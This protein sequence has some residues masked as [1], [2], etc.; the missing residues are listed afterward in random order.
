[1]AQVHLDQGVPAWTVQ[2]DTQGL[3]PLG[4]QNTSIT[5]YQ[6]LL[7]GISNVTL[8]MRYWSFHTWLTAEYARAHHSA[9]V[10]EWCRFLR[11]G[12]ALYA[13]IAQHNTQDI[14]V[15]GNLW[16][17]RK[18]QELRGDRLAF[19]TFTDRKATTQY[20]QQKFGAFGAA[21][22]S[23]LLEVG[24]IE[25]AQNHDVPVP[26]AEGW[27]LARSFADEIRSF[28]ELFLEV[29][30]RGSVTLAELARMAAMT[31]SSIDE[32]TPECQQY[33]KILFAAG[34]M[35]G[36]PATRRRDTLRLVLHTAH[37]LQGLPDADAVRWV[38]YA[39]HDDKGDAL[40]PL[41]GADG[42]HR[43]RW[44]VYH[45]NDLTHICH[46]SLL[47]YILEVLEGYPGG[48]PLRPLLAEVIERLLAVPATRPRS[49]AELEASVDL[50]A[51]AWSEETDA[52]W[53]LANALL[54]VRVEAALPAQTAFEALRLLAVLGRRLRP[55]RERMWQVLRPAAHKTSQTVFT[56]M[57]F[58]HARRDTPIEELLST[59]LKQRILDRHLAVAFQKLRAGDYTFLFELDEG[60]L[61]LRRKAIAVLTNPRLK[62]AIRFLGDIH[63]LDDSGLTPAGQ[64]M[65]GYA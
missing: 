52:E 56:E 46:E 16:A 15:A 60:R 53:Q 26:T 12:E 61:Q 51:N 20:L 30:N 59:F 50:P 19:S 34:A 36:E 48:V 1:M 14:G 3:D 18:L 21:Y 55:E 4:M 37:E 31:P 27:K 47:R 54:G 24:L 22:A 65:V 57:E 10:D 11:R 58:L 64:R 29:A 35:G 45:A 25:Q 43:Y 49:W 8:R 9:D 41:S 13:L 63:L 38:C 7:P 40:A 62:P 32:G 17:K 23:Q 33:E 5:L 39:G 44:R 28:G 42:E 6:Q 2:S